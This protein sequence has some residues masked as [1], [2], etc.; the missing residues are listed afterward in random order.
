MN[1]KVVPAFLAAAAM[2]VGTA[3]LRGHQPQQHQHQMQGQDQPQ[4]GMMDE[5]K[6]MMAEHQK[7]MA[8]LNEA[9]QQLDG[10]VAKMNSASG[11]QKTDAVA[12]VVTEMVSQRKSMRDRMMG[13]QHKMMMH[14]GGHMQQGG[15]GSMAMCP[16]MR[17]MK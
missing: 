4:A 2:M 9:D 10:L 7:M 6:A 3:A 13:M 17:E 5:C 14:M 1:S 8:E 11:A 16:M 12:A 15:K